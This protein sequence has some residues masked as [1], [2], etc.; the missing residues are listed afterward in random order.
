MNENTINITATASFIETESDV[1][2]NRYIFAYTITIA[3]TG[4]SAAQLLERHWIL[5][6]ANGKVDEVHGAGVIGR[7]PRIK[8]GECFQ[9]TSSAI[10][11]TDVGIMQGHYIFEDDEGEL[12]N[13]EIPPFTLSIPRT[14][15]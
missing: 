13:A 14:L 6:N 8:G 10:I 12:F 3:N 5:I 9:Y 4:K 1:S 15:H 7:K 11:D 2:Q